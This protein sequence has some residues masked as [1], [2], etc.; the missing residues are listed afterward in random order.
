MQKCCRCSCCYVVSKIW[1]LDKYGIWLNWT[2]D[3]LWMYVQRRK[4]RLRRQCKMSSSKN[5]PVKGLAAG[6]YL[7][8]GQ[9]PIPPPPLIT[10]Y[11][12]ALCSILIHTEKGGGRVEP[13]IMLEGQQFTQLGGKY[14]RDC[15]YLQSINSL[16][17]NFFRWRH[18]ALLSI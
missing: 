3:V 13:E 16:N 10:V 2:Y 1:G 4:I 18:S 9:N 7:S 8:E 5:W 17:V 12:Y 14:Q 11:V 6:V 15:L